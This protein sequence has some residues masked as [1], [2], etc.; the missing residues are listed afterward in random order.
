MIEEKAS[1]LRT[2]VRES[3]RAGH[4][5]ARERLLKINRLEEDALFFPIDGT[6]HVGDPQQ[7]VDAVVLDAVEDAL[8]LRLPM[9]RVVGEESIRSV[10]GREYPIAVVDPVDG[11]K[12]FTH[13]GECWAVVLNMLQFS[14]SAGHLWIPAAG[15]ATSTGM[16]VGVWEERT[17]TVELLE[18]E[19]TAVTVLDCEPRGDRQL[20]LACVGAKAADAHRYSTLRQAFP[21]ATVFNTG[22]NPV[23]VGVLTGDL[24]GIVSFDRQCSWDA[25]YALAVS[26]AGGTIGATTHEEVFEGS[27]V[28]SWFRQPLQGAAEEVK[29]VPPI[30]AAK[31][32]NTYLGIIAGLSVGD[33]AQRVG[34]GSSQ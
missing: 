1:L 18:E 31:D 12:P 19:A 9:I 7:V 23:V 22:G 2:A 15:I 30:V 14:P 27:E 8:R 21:K 10:R 13:L 24:D 6:R 32:R 17:V 5:A 11:T 29:T 16:L 34:G 3:L 26:L 25:T 4:R 33:L 28:L 20:S